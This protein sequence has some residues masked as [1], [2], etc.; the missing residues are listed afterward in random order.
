MYE[1]MGVIG[2]G[3]FATVHKVVLKT[4]GVI[5]AA[6]ELDK[7]RFSKEGKLDPGIDNEIEILQRI[8]H[9]SFYRPEQ[10]AYGTYIFTAPYCLIC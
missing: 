5:Y 1:F 8:K 9:V 10:S 4:D 2:K 6:K 7:R 3:A